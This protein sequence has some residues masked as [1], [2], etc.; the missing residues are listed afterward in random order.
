LL[1]QQQ[2]QR[3]QMP[4]SIQPQAPGQQQQQQ[5]IQTPQ[6]QQPPQQYYNAPAVGLPLPQTNLHPSGKP[7]RPMNA[8]LVFSSVRRPELQKLFPDLKTAALSKRL[9]EEWRD[10]STVS[11]FCGP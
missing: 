4:G 5:Q 3:Q 7:K 9:G 2:L 6:Q 10:M 1:R 8:F 11:F